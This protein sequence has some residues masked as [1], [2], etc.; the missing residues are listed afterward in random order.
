MRVWRIIGI[1]TYWALWPLIY[2]YSF[3]SKARA[4]VIIVCGE[5]VLLVKNW[6]GPNKWALPGGGLERGESVAHA[7]RRELMEELRLDV[8]EQTIT[9]HGRYVYKGRA[10]ML[11]KYQLC[12]LHLQT[13][14]LLTHKPDEIMDSR[15]MK[16]SN[17]VSEPADV[18]R[19]VSAAMATWLDSQNLV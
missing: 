14:P 6:L 19:S 12:S 8:P 13:K 16:I 4:R 18:S 7:A 15:W 9:V 1:T 11:V 3:T 17:V 10:N 5:E 2:I